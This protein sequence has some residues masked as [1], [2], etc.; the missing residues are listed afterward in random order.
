MF[1]KTAFVSLRFF[2][3]IEPARTIKNKKIPEKSLCKKWFRK[4]FSLLEQNYKP[5]RK[6]CTHGNDQITSEMNHCHMTLHG[7]SEMH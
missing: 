7:L 1:R 2:T 5:C 4:D 6:A 3:S